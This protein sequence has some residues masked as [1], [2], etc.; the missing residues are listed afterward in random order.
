MND[1]AV[2]SRNFIMPGFVV[3][4]QSRIPPNHLHVKALR[5]R[6]VMAVKLT[7]FIEHDLLHRPAEGSIHNPNHWVQGGAADGKGLSTRR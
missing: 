5:G 2:P 7:Q 4:F 1:T 6:P 3:F